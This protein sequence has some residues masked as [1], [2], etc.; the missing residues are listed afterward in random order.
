MCV[1]GYTYVPTRRNACVS[2]SHRKLSFSGFG[3]KLAPFMDRLVFHDLP[4]ELQHQSLRPRHVAE[5]KQEDRERLHDADA[6]QALHSRQTCFEGS[7]LRVHESRLQRR[8]PD[9]VCGGP[10]VGQHP[11]ARSSCFDAQVLVYFLS[12]GSS[13]QRGHGL[14]SMNWPCLAGGGSLLSGHGRAACF[15]RRCLSIE[16]ASTARR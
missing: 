6:Q 8:P 15:D 11:E 1:C 12:F 14:S 13:F 16:L 7:M 3:F 2:I 4:G 5:G 10:E 9:H